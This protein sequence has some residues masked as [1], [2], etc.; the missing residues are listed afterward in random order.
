[1]EYYSDW[2]DGNNTM[3]RE[4]ECEGEGEERGGEEGRGRARRTW[5]D[6]IP[7]PHITLLNSVHVKASL[8][9]D[10]NRSVEC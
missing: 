8:P 4:G 1:M 10:V 3:E 5:D 9:Y 7:A 2:R 6:T